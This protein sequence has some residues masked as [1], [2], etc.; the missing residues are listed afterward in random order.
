[1]FRTISGIILV[2]V[3]AF[4]LLGFVLSGQS[5]LAPATLFAL[6]VAVI[7]PA[8]TGAVL[9]KPSLVPRGRLQTNKAEIRRRTLQSE[10]LRL[11]GERQGRITIVEVVEAFAVTPE[12]AKDVLDALALEGMADFAV[13]DSGMV[14]YDFRELR[15]LEDKSK[16]R[17]ILDD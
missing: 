9:L 17:G 7:V 4:M 10:V 14:V 3:A 13:T 5:M 11:A 12:E 1:V 2:C 16:A 8:V 6:L 15:Q